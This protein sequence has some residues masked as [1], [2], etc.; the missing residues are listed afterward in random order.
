MSSRQTIQPFDVIVVA[1]GSSRRMGGVDKLDALVAGRPVLAWS[2]WAFAR[3]AEARRIVVVTSADRVTRYRAAAWMPQRVSAVIA[4]GARRQESVA[5]GIR[6]LRADEASGDLRDHA[7]DRVVLVHDGARPVISADLIVRVAAAAAKHGAAIPVVSVSETI[8]EL[9][10]G[11]VRRTVDRAH[12]A[13]AQTPQGVRLSVLERAYAMFPPDSRETWTDE[14]A[15]LEAC[16][17][18]VHAL[19]GDADNLKVTYP[20]DLARAARALGGQ[21]SFAAGRPGFGSD[22]HPFGA[23]R[24]LAL[25]G[26]EIADAPRLSGHSDGDVALHAVADALLGAAGLGDLGRQFPADATTPAGLASGQMLAGV[27]ELLADAGLSPRSVDLTIVAGRP[28]LG[29]RLDEMRAEIARILGVDA[30]GVSVKASSG[31][32]SGD[33]GAGRA[34]SAHAI[35]VVAP[36]GLGR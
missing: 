27:V 10:G 13:A 3:V 19:S 17:I 26:I 23:D 21:L 16:T 5:A 35:A 34:I 33:E 11:V 29:G 18:T 24:P 20:P 8:K 36:L 28:H 1:A 32:L 15:L 25:G 22:S 7:A 31:N 4:G 12:L 6:W 14:A 30:G 9:D 2:T